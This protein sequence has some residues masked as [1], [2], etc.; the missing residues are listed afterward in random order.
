MMPRR[1]AALAVP[2]IALGAGAGTGLAADGPR[3][4][5]IDQ[6]VAAAQTGNPELAIA[7]KGVVVAGKRVGAAKALRLPSLS[8]TANVFVWDSELT[9]PLTAPGTMLPPGTE[10]PEL[11]A[12]EQITGSVS[13]T[14]AQ[15]LS[16]LAVLSKLIDVEESGV[17][18]AKSEVDGARLDVGAQ[19]AELYFRAMEAHAYAQIA[20]QSVQQ[21]DAQLKQARALEAAGVLERVQ[22]MRLEAA[23]AQAEQAALQARDGEAQ[24]ID[25]LAMLIGLPVGT[26]LETVDQLPAEIPPPPWTEKQALEVAMQKRPDLKTADLRAQQASGAVNVKLA[27]YYP[28]VNAVAQYQHNEG[29]GSFAEEDSLFVGVTL[30]W[31]IWNWGKTRNDVAELRGRAQQARM[32]ADR[33]RDRAAVDVRA[34]L[35]TAGSRYEQLA[36]AKRGLAAA[37]EA[38]RLATARFAA[39]QDTQLGVIDAEA[40]VT[41]ARLSLATQRYEYAIALV[42]LARAIGEAPL[43]AF[44][45]R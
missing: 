22:V 4:L 35:R 16:G 7:Q 20:E 36:V 23:R 14:V 43:A 42:Q 18:V 3:R 5:T 44:G 24:A 34:K 17:A 45:S 26:P 33:M 25:G 37:E 12:R 31:N 6:A 11:V 15:P 19:A 21:L 27:D 41:R 2:L 8:V 38:Y 13:V 9:F 29:Q 32:N 40:E 28:N 30:S 39:G 1:L 10:A